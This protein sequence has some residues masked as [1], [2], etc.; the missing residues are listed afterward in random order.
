MVASRRVS[1]IAREI[2]E[3]VSVAGFDLLLRAARRISEGELAGVRYYGS[4]MVTLDLEASRAEVRDRCDVAT[5]ARLARLLAAES[6][7][8]S[9]LRALAEGEARRIAS[10]PLGPL[11]V[12]VEV[13]AEGCRVLVDMDVEGELALPRTRARGPGL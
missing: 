11:E 5:A 3:R 4:T 13:R 10:R 9:R 6:E 12:D 2:K 7:L 1:L 8:L